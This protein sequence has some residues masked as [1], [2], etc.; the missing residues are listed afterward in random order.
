MWGIFE[1][2]GMRC[3]NCWRTVHKRCYNKGMARCNENKMA[4]LDGDSDVSKD[5]LIKSEHK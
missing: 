4:V 5:T 1:E 3:K 2:Q